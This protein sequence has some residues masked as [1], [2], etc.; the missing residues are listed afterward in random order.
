MKGGER[1]NLE[2]FIIGT[3]LGL[4]LSTGIYLLF[5]IPYTMID[6]WLF[7]RRLKKMEN[8]PLKEYGAFIDKEFN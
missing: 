3:L 7:D 6:M 8:K 4:I 2:Y 5:A 1:M